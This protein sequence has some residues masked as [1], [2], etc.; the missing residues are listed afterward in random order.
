MTLLTRS[1]PIAC[2]MLAAGAAIAD[3]TRD[4]TDIAEDAVLTWAEGPGEEGARVRMFAGEIDGRGVVYAEYYRGDRLVMAV[5]YHRVFIDNDSESSIR[6]L[7]DLKMIG[8]TPDGF[9]F[10]ADEVT[11]RLKCTA[12]L[13]ADAT[14]NCTRSTFRPKGAASCAEF[15]KS[16]GERAQCNGIREHYKSPAIPHDDLAAMC[17]AGFRSENHRSQCMSFGY[18]QPAPLFREA[19][20]ACTSAYKPTDERMYCLVFTLGTT[21]EQKIAPAV[22]RQCAREHSD[23]KAITDCAFF[24]KTGVKQVHPKSRTSEPT[25]NPTTP[26]AN[27]ATPRKRRLAGARIDVAIGTWQGLSLRATGGM[28]ESEPV[29][30]VD[31]FRNEKLE[32]TQPVDRIVVGKQVRA[33]REVSSLDKVKLAGELLT[34]RVVLGGKRLECRT[35]AA[36]MF[37]RC[38]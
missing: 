14:I 32:W 13:H 18:N 27:N 4:D 6:A 3:P 1:I 5:P 30:W 17:A 19:L 11:V 25:D 33:L 9:A 21:E 8:P 23:D 10:E 26:V 7:R 37:A 38:R 24:V 35:D 31:A 36:R 16:H 15:F 29:L 12:L 2:A 34:F 20:S 28:V 22:V